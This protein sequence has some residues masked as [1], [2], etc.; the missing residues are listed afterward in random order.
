VLFHSVYIYALFRCVSCF[1]FLRENINPEREKELVDLF[2]HFSAQYQNNLRMIGIMILQLFQRQ[3]F[4]DKEIKFWQNWIPSMK[5]KMAVSHAQSSTPAADPKSAS[6]KSRGESRETGRGNH[7]HHDDD[8]S[9]L[10]M[11]SDHHD[12]LSV[13]EGRR[14]PN[15]A[16]PSQQSAEDFSVL[17]DKDVITNVEKEFFYLLPDAKNIPEELKAILAICFAPITVP[18]QDINYTKTQ[19]SLIMRLPYIKILME[20][21]EELEEIVIMN[22]NDKHWIKQSNWTEEDE[23]LRLE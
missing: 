15:S 23:K 2:S 21:L 7:N 11:T 17:T 9:V 1:L 4:T 19:F 18:F 8:I 16:I 3:V 12:G 6:R 13:N 10:S 20:S 14:K 22:E 5:A